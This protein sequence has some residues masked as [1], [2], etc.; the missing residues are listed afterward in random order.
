MSYNKDDFFMHYIT[1]AVDTAEFWEDCI[2][3]EEREVNKIKGFK[4]YVDSGIFV[5]VELE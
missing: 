2:T 4:D 3:E 1:G 5:K